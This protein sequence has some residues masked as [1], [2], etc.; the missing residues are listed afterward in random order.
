MA[1]MSRQNVAAGHADLNIKVVTSDAAE[2][3]HIAVP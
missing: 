3:T 2:S 1:T